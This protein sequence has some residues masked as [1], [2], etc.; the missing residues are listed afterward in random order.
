MMFDVG[1]LVANTELRTKALKMKVEIIFFIVC[2][3][4]VRQVI[5][6][7]TLCSPLYRRY[8]IT[9]QPLYKNGEEKEICRLLGILNRDKVLTPQYFQGIQKFLTAFGFDMVTLLVQYE[10]E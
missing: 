2:I 4:P 5:Q 9:L 10:G 8:D 7:G 3:V 6:R 1:V